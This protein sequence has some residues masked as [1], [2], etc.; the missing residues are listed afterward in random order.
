MPLP[1]ITKTTDNPAT[2]IDDVANLPSSSAYQC[3]TFILDV[4]G[5]GFT[6][7]DV[8]WAVTDSNDDPVTGVISAGQ[9]T[10]QA[11]FE[12]PTSK[13]PGEY[14]IKACL[15]SA[16]TDCSTHTFTLLELP[17]ITVGTPNQAHVG[18]H[19]QFNTAYPFAV[20][21][22]PAEVG[23]TGLAT[24]ATSGVKTVTYTPTGHS[25]PITLE[26]LVYSDVAV[27]EYDDVN[28]IYLNSG[29]STT[30]TV[31]G[32]SGQY[33]FSITGQNSISPTGVI[34]AGIYAGEYTVT[35]L[36][37]DAGVIKTIPICVGSQSQFC[38]EAEAKTC[39]T[40]T[41]SSCCE[42]SVECG[43]SVL[44]K[45]PTFHM[46]V[47]GVQEEIKYT[48]YGA[49]SVGEAGYLRSGSTGFTNAEA[50]VIKCDATESLFEIVTS[51]D[52]SNVANEPFGIGFSQYQNGSGVNSIDVAAVW[53]TDASTRYIEVRKAG[54]AQLGSK[55]AILQGDVV[56]AGYRNGT[57]VVYINN[58]L[59]YENSEITCC[60][61]QYLD[62][63]IEEPNKS[64][65]GNLAGLTWTI[66]TPGSPADVGS[67]NSSGLYVAPTGGSFGLVQA[68]ATVGNATFRINIRNIKP[69]LRI[70]HPNAFL[71]GRSVEIWVGKYT[72][73]FNEP[74]RLAKDGTPDSIQNPGMINLGTLEGSANFQEEMQY[75][76]FDNDLGTYL[77]TISKESAQLTAT[78]LEVRD[79][80]KMANLMPHATLHAK[81]NGT[82]EI[83]VGGKTCGVGELRV[84]MV[85]GQASCDDQYDVLYIP[86][87]QNK[88]NLGLEVGRKAGGK[89]ALTFTA[90]PDYTRPTGKQLYSIYQIDSCS[91]PSCN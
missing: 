7:G 26:Y 33:I 63:A 22:S 24:W 14:T 80:Y 69:S 17:P 78:F 15:T 6:T 87:V 43:E 82:R 23:S 51:L 41:A 47:N 59:K 29:D 50:N 60:G 91:S 34:Q 86:R 53:F 13:A 18:G 37:N 9:N 85:V 46:R 81:T 89:Y 2:T 75:Q 76:D 83:S 88:G 57:F 62:L 77:T 3:T 68:E 45:V 5:P 73:G 1:I 64:L 28:C 66:T 10:I 8:T 48:G 38:V 20:T 49:G 19:T 4:K 39:A 27:A 12:F 67:I 16:P 71:A 25:C 58:L 74:I 35:I 31:T 32:G 61:T 36:D 84:I 11:T 30:L 56:S 21:W 90:L 42:L 70:T 44:L 54:V 52:M 65:G 79:L 72:P 55:F 40:E